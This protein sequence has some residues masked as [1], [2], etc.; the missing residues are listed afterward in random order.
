MTK[1]LRSLNRFMLQFAVCTLWLPTGPDG[2]VSGRLGCPV[3]TLRFTVPC[4]LM[5]RLQM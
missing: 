1:G 4:T 2:K 3:K 5:V